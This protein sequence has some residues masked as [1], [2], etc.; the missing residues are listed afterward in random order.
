MSFTPTRDELVRMFPRAKSDWI[1]ALVKLAPVLCQHYGFNRLRWVHFAGQIAAETNSLT[2][3]PMAENLNYSASR[4]LEVFSYRLGKCIADRQP[5]MGQVYTSKTALARALAG[6]PHELACV[7]YGGREGTPPYD[8][9]YFGRGP[10]QT[11]HLNNY[12]T[13]GN[14]IAKQP[15]GS[16]YDLVAKPELLATDAEL[17]VRA[18]FAEWK[19][20]GLN[21]WADRDDCDAVSDVLN[22]GNNKD[23]VKPHGL[24][25]RRMETA[26]AKGI[27][28]A[29]RDSF[30][31]PAA[32]GP[33]SI[34]GQPRTLRQ[35][36]R[37]PDVR[38][39]QE[40]LVELKYQVGIIDE[41]FG[42]QVRRA[43]VAL[44]TEH[45]LHI[46]GVVGPRTWDVINTTAAVPNP[47]LPVAVHT[48]QTLLASGSKT[49]ALWMRVYNIG[50]G[51][52]AL[53]FG[54]A[55]AEALGID[56]V[57][58]ALTTA[59]RAGTLAERMA[60]IAVNK[61]GWAILGLAAV[62]VLFWLLS[63]TATQGIE[64]RVEK[65]NNGQDVSH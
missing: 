6:K 40:R 62:G 61:Q 16:A 26:K 35:G 31:I 59:E 38:K 64:E 1:D 18:A 9:R 63:R 3:Y 7:V 24:P 44:Q 10:L 4:M 50:R 54:A 41:K 25:R 51:A 49:I 27:W 21:T 5:V 34:A 2:L 39:L 57:D 11:T 19:I 14:E 47:D 12:R 23:K 32:D 28:P 37:G 13:T 33:N 15:G 52:Y 55:G 48:P 60:G 8:G 56:V 46:D 53:A 17:G 45:E 58:T 43:V 29:D 30:P 65:A 20:K 36:D 22:T 42:V